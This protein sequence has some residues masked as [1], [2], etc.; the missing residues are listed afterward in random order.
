MSQ[1][2]VKAT[3]ILTLANLTSKI[4]GFVYV[5]PFTLLV[6]AEGFVLF[7]YAYK[8]YAVLLIL[9][10]MGIP[11]GVSKIVS[12]YNQIGRPDIGVHLLRS[13]I[14][15]LGIIGLISFSL[16]YSMAPNIA[17]VVVD[18]RDQTGNS[19]EEVIFVIR[20]VS[21]ALLVVPPM[22]IVRGFFQGQQYMKPTAVSQVV[23]QLVRVFIII[24]GTFVLIKLWGTD[25]VTAVGVATFGT[26]IGA[27]SSCLVLYY[28]YKQNPSYFQ[29]KL[30]VKSISYSSIYKELFSYAIPIAIVSLAVP[31]YQMVDTFT[32]N[33][34][35][36]AMGATQA[37][38]ETVNALIGLVQKVILI[39]VALAT[40]FAYTLVPAITS[41]YTAGDQ[42]LLH[43]QMKK[44]YQS[45]LVVTVPA[46]CGLF[47][48]SSLAFGSAFGMK[49]AT[50]GGWY[51]AWYA[52][53]GILF[54]LFIITAAMLQ[55]IA[56]QKQAMYSF[57]VG[58]MLKI[59]LNYWLVK[60]IGGNGSTVATEIG[61]F[62]SIA[63][64]VRVLKKKTAFS[65]CS[66]KKDVAAVGA[67]CAIMVTLV[68]GINMW[69]DKVMEVSY[70]AYVLRL[71]LA[72]LL[73]ASVYTGLMYR[74]SSFQLIF[75]SILRKT[76]K[77][78]T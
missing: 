60:E 75:G 45:I 42:G 56:E 31:L 22:A 21:F 43:E 15:F 25:V 57:F 58:V 4:L 62:V 44:T 59:S 46:V 2:L 8:P 64:N 54:S 73:G 67:S 6:G 11:L 3:V 70:I 49:Y 24:V 48:V 69:A 5:I 23:E 77:Q 26:V 34:A 28:Y 37:E 50:E 47:A 78:K 12:K 13:G 10:T 68:F 71:M 18:P 52:P 27:L 65:L 7:E 51:L 55:G 19:L 33:R 36:M 1:D 63:W 39:P 72:V 35:L 38:A 66:I 9:S 20:M 16:L 14:V 32:I 53:I 40:G 29:V 41:S 30:G 61:F 76:G 17:R 74:T